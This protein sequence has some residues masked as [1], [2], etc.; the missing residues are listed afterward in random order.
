MRHFMVVA[1][2]GRGRVEIVAEVPLTVESLSLL[3]ERSGLSKAL[4]AGAGL[5]YVPRAIE[6]YLDGVLLWRQK[7]HDRGETSRQSATRKRVPRTVGLGAKAARLMA[8][9]AYATW[10]ATRDEYMTDEFSRGDVAAATREAGSQV[11]SE[12]ATRM[13]ECPPRP[14]GRPH[15]PVDGVLHSVPTGN[16][17]RKFKR[18]RLDGLRRPYHHKQDLREG[19]V[20]TWTTWE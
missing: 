16:P 5:E 7:C 3:Q 19:W 2:L 4:V 13:A 11:T 14:A 6:V 8:N 15:P 12:M 1:D 17:T 20:M 10:R 18:I 9:R